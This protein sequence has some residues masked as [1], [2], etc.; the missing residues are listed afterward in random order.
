MRRD[1]VRSRAL[2]GARADPD[3]TTVPAELLPCWG[4][5]FLSFW[6]VHAWDEYTC[7]RVCGIPEMYACTERKEVFLTWCD[8][9][10]AFLIVVRVEKEPHVDGA[11][12]P[13]G[14]AVRSF[15]PGAGAALV[16]RGDSGAVWV[17]WAHER[18]LRAS[19]AARLS[20]SFR[21]VEQCCH[22]S[23]LGQ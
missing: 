14:I 16:S 13:R 21:L 23:G 12:H 15:L 1:T 19:D 6:D 18:R 11:P 17:H 20:V 3:K 9:I 10:E 5:E 8:K 2:Q 22:H 7:S 4:P